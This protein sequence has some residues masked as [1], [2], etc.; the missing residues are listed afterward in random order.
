MRTSAG[1]PT[2]LLLCRLLH[3]AAWQEGRQRGH[4]VEEPLAER[5]RLGLV[6]ARP[7][8]QAQAG[9]VG[10]AG[11]GGR[12]INGRHNTCPTCAALAPGLVQAS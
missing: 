5:Q 1:W 3:L 9:H 10:Q 11:F 7:T 2:W 12:T 4:P 8:L 6:G